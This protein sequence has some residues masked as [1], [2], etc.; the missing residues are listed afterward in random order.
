MLILLNVTN[1]IT[2]INNIQ[3]YS[4]KQIYLH[5]ET[6]IYYIFFP[7]TMFYFIYFLINMRD[8][9]FGIIL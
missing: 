8:S 2:F 3:F 6:K 4:G 5:D 7:A 9:F 1:K